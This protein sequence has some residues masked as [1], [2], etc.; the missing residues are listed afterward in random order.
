MVAWIIRTIFAR[1]DTEHG[2]TQLGEV[3]RMLGRRTLSQTLL[4]PCL[5]T[6]IPTFKGNRGLE[7]NRDR[8]RQYP[9]CGPLPCA[10]R[11]GMRTKPF[12]YR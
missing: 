3:T 11:R 1:P 4:T 7:P 12:L 6:D 9:G 5:G 10:G 2:L 8:G